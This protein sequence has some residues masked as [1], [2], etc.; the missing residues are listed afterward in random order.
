MFLQLCP[1]CEHRNPRGSR[2]CNECGS[3]LQLRFCPACHAA[4]D[5]M[6]LKC[7]SCGEKLPVMVL[8]DEAVDPTDFP[9]NTENIWKDD[10]PT[11]TFAKRD[12]DVPVT[13]H[14]GD[15]PAPAFENTAPAPAFANTATESASSVIDEIIAQVNPEPSVI[16]EIIAQVEPD[17]RAGSVARAAQGQPATQAESGARAE[18]V[19]Q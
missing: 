14:G 9:V 11:P 17:T 19:A 5:V 3:P 13:V 10:A 18:S 15:A 2:F 7:S 16:D 1:V 6:S 12:D 4:E 8:T